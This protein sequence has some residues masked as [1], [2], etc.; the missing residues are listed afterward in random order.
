VGDIGS[1]G[2]FGAVGEERVVAATRAMICSSLW[3]S[4]SIVFSSLT[5]AD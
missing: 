5:H 1:V 3:D 4:I 2:R